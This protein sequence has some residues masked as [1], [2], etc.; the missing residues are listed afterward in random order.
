M[1]SKTMAVLVSAGILSGFPAL[2]HAQQPMVERGWYGGV[3]IGSTWVKMDDGALPMAGST[4]SSLAKDESASV[5]GLGVGY[6]FSRNWAL[7]GGYTKNGKFSA[8]RTSTAGTT[9]TFGAQSD[10]SA[11]Y[12]SGLGKWP[13]NPQLYLFGKLGIAATTVKTTLDTT[14]AFALPAGTSTSRKKSETNLLWGLGAGYDFNR[15][16]GLRLDYTQI[17]NAGDASTGERD[18]HA[19]TAALKFR[20]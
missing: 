6:D 15:S 4:A 18:I 10:G 11:W 14:G 16:F 13:V 8:R 20:F 5:F 9:G 17:A 19:V 3:A 7:E 1:Q 2:V 12:L